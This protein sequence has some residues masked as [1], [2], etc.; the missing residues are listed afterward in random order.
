MR[1]IWRTAKVLGP[2]LGALLWS[3]KH[4]ADSNPSSDYELKLV[5]VLFRH[6]AR[7]P[8][9]SIPGVMEVWPSF[10][11]SDRTRRRQQQRPKI[12]VTCCLNLFVSPKGPVGAK[13]PGPAGAHPHRLCRNQ[14]GGR[15]QASGSSGGQ[16]SQ[17]HSDRE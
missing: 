7:T 4:T 17:K 3:K 5:Q 14:S 1:N 8:L 12:H 9:K 16:L 13:P 15:A 11:L 2:A 10:S 6:G